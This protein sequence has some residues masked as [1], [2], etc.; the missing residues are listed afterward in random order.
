MVKSYY[1]LVALRL[2]EGQS[3]DDVR[4]LFGIGDKHGPP[5]L[6][7]DETGL[8]AALDGGVRAASVIV[9]SESR[10]AVL[11]KEAFD[12]LMEGRNHVAL[13]FQIAVLRR[14][15]DDLTAANSRLV[16]LASLPDETMSL[17][18]LTDVVYGSP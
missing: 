11:P 9:N 12:G 4:A 6:S 3:A 1:P 7:D 14:L 18:A 10:V 13:G 17:Q 2:V 8:L 15:S 5:P 16:E